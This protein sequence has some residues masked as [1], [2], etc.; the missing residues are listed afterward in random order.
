LQQL[1]QLANFLQ[2][3]FKGSSIGSFKVDDGIDSLLE[4]IELLEHTFDRQESN[5]LL[6]SATGCSKDGLDKLSIRG[7]S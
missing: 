7:E 3:S 6:E 4:V 1:K 2:N 5:E